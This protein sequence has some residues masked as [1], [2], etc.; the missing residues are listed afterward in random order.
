[1][2]AACVD[3]FSNGRFILGLG[4][5]HKVQV[6]PEHG[7]EF[8]GPI[9]RVRDTVDIVR[10]LLRDG[11]VTD[12]QGEAIGIASFDLHFP[13]FRPE[14]PIYLAAVF[15]KMLEIAGEISQGVLLTWCTPEYARTASEHIAAGASRAGV[16][17]DS[18]EVGDAGFGFRAWRRRQR[19]AAGGRNLRRAVPQVPSADGRSGLR[20]RG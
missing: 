8:A 15:P 17:P 9:P 18:V 13:T 2:A 7:L 19:D 12:Y 5:S 10:R 20:R 6:E 11:V 14:I 3:H 1:M 16:A 4:S